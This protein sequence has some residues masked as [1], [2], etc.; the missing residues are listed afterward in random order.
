[1]FGILLAMLLEA[2]TAPSA[3]TNAD[4]VRRP[5][6]SD[7]ARFYPEGARQRGL[8]GRATLSCLVTAEGELANCSVSDES[9]ADQGFGAAALSLSTRFKMGAIMKDGRPV[10]GGSVRIPIRFQLPGADVDPITGLSLCYGLSAAAAQIN[11]SNLEAMSAY[12][13]YAAQ[14]AIKSAQA[15][16]SPEM[17]EARL[18]SA[19]ALALGGAR[20]PDIDVSLRQCLGFIPKP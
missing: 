11:P 15:H 10:A 17:F 5:N 13:F 12:G 19:R 20:A 6:P 18:G 3:I 9:P 4:W 1:M 16:T 8:A 7:L 14:L 2:G